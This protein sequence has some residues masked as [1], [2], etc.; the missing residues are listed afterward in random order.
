MVDLKFRAFASFTTGAALLKTGANF[1]FAAQA[2]TFFVIGYPTV[3]VS[4]SGG[5]TP[6]V[7]EAD[8]LSMAS[9]P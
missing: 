3:D 4:A 8:R 7:T 6:N 1:G 2:I 9:P 5:Q